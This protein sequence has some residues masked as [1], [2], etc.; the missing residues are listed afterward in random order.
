GTRARARRRRGQPRRSCRRAT[1]T[2]R[3]SRARDRG[4]RRAPFR[5][6]YDVAPRRRFGRRASGERSEGDRSLAGP[7][8]RRGPSAPPATG[9]PRDGRHDRNGVARLELRL[10]PIEKANVLFADV[11]VDETAHAL[12]VDEAVPDPGV[13]LLQVLDEVGDS[14][15]IG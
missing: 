5:F 2:P 12:L 9:A 4:P 7:V 13:L 11:D 6:R 1:H 8:T 3:R 14:A 15:P 10:Q